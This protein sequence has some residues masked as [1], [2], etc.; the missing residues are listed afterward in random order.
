[1]I[2]EIIP[3]YELAISMRVS[4][5]AHSLSNI[6]SRGSNRMWPRRQLLADGETT[7]ALSGNIAKRYHAMALAEY[8]LESGVHLCSACAAHDGRRAAAL[9]DQGRKDLDMA[10]ILTCGLCDAHGFLVTAKKIDDESG[11]S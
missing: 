6:G 4:L 7:D 5:Q 1:M 8:L 11:S 3:I 2:D 10:E 9:I